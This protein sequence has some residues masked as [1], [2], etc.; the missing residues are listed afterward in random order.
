MTVRTSEASRSLSLSL[1]FSV[2]DIATFPLFTPIPYRID[3]TTETTPARRRSQ[4]EPRDAAV[5]PSPP[6]NPSEMTL[7]LWRRTNVSVGRHAAEMTLKSIAVQFLGA[8]TRPPEPVNDNVPEKEWVVT[9]AADA[10]TKTK[11]KGSWVQNAQFWS[12]FYL[13]VPPTFKTEHGD[14]LRMTC[15]VSRQESARS[16]IIVS[17]RT[18]RDPCAVP[19][20]TPCSF[21]GMRKRSQS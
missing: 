21:R 19:P 9:Q 20:R 8:G 5:F 2:P 10:R 3:I 6:R 16:A 1:Q 15:E 18:H 4:D 13:N 11:E 17:P 12:H 7:Q 14:H